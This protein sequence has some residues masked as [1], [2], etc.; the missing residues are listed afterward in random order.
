MANEK[1]LIERFAERLKEAYPEADRNNPC[2]A[3]YYDFF[4]EMVDE[5]AAEMS[6]NRTDAPT[7]DAVEVVRC[8]VR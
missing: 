5:V 3:L 1:L 4:C 2:P 6:V 8:K 7:V